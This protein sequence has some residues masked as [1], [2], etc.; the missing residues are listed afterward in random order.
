MSTRKRCGSRQKA[1][2]PQ[3]HSREFKTISQIPASAFPLTSSRET[4]LHGRD[5]VQMSYTA[6][7]TH[8][9]FICQC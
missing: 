7:M 5:V 1:C 8:F 3:L 6:I 2:L 9:V 4:E